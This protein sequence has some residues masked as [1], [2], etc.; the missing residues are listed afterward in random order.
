MSE[1]FT[2]VD[3]PAGRFRHQ[4]LW[5]ALEE[6]SLA[7]RGVA[8]ARLE[9]PTY[10]SVCQRASRHG[11]VFHQRKQPDGSYVIWLTPRANGHV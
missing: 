6:A 4:D 3:L 10:M 11:L 2:I 8:V 7:N 5:D 1:H 9:R